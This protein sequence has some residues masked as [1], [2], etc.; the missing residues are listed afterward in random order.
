[1]VSFAVVER[2]NK[3]ETVS[4]IQCDHLRPRLPP[5]HFRTYTQFSS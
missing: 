2:L 1:M 4:I 5:H 3:D